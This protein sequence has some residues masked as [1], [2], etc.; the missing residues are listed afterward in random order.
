[1]DLATMEKTST[2]PCN[3]RHEL[4]GERKME[5]A[6][7]PILHVEVAH[8]SELLRSSSVEDL[9]QALNAVHLDILAVRVL[10]CWII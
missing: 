8:G 10:N 4:C 9:Q 5:G 2:K 3:F 7:L 6:H 1:M